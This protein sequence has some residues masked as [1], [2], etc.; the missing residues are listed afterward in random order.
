[1]FLKEIWLTQIFVKMKT[2]SL[3]LFL[4]IISSSFVL[5]APPELPMI[6]SG[7]VYINEKPAKVGTGITAFVDGEEFAS[8][9]INEAGMFTILLQKLEEGQKV[10]FYVDEIFT[11]ESISYES[12]GF[13]QLTLKVEKSYL[14][15]YLGVAIVLLVAGL[16]IWKRK[17]I[18]KRKKK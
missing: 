4:L 16:L 7:E 9:E 18:S 12:S 1:M 6:V 2:F 3:L 11:N 5:A 13:E 8:S 15:Y 14:F 17:L 10:E